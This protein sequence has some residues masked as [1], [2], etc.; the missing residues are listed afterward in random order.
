MSNKQTEAFNEHV[1]EKKEELAAA[2]LLG[3][4]G[5]EVTKRRGTEYFKEIGRLGAAKRWPS[6][7]K[8]LNYSCDNSA[9][10]EYACCLTCWNTH[11]QAQK[12]EDRSFD[13][14]FREWRDK[15]Y[16]R[17]RIAAAMKAGFT[18]S[19]AEYLAR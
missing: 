13:N 3:K 7:K 12:Y 4:R 1:E 18:K 6:L 15:E 16:R 8:D 5:G 9:F 2:R 17:R 14:R 19:Q 11:P 10:H